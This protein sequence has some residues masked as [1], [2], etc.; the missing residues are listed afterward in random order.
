MPG[1]THASVLL[2]ESV[3]ALALKPEGTYVDATFGRGGHARAILA[4]LAPRGRLVAI[5]RDPDAARAALAIADARLLFQR[6]RFS[7][8]D[9]VL[10][11]LGI[12]LVDGVLLDLGVSSPQIDTPSRGFSFRHEGPLDMRMDPDAGEPAAAFI[13]RAS[14]REL[15]EVI[16][17]HGEERLAQPIARAIVAARAVRPIVTTRELAAIVAQAVGARTRGDW[18]Q[19]PATRTFQALRIAVNDELAELER[20]LPRAV[21]RLRERG[22]LAVISFH[23]LEDR[24]VKRFVARASTPFGGEPRLAR[25]PLT[26][27]ELPVPPLAA[28]GR[29][30]KPSAA[31]CD[32]N[33]RARSAVLRV[34]ERTAAPLP[35]DW[36]LASAP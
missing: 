26:D 33:P 27:A 28:V 25:A 15:T 23:S 11:A 17:D 36:P 20:V 12:A 5:D 9:R 7:A 22:R 13:A 8:L 21:A 1:A 29:A 10:D 24:I 14:L 2:E 16:R 32:A 4:R 19:D 3:A 35:G 18:R 6:E 31:E 30:I 34:A